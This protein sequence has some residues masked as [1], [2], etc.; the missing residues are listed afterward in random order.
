MSVFRIVG[1]RKCAFAGLFFFLVLT[2][3]DCAYFNTFYLAKRDFN[4]GE[5]FRKRDGEVRPDNRKYYTQAIE[6]ASL[7]LQDYRKSRYVDDSLSIIGMSYFQTGDYVR[8]KTKF[9]EI[10][11]AFP[12]GNYAEEAKFYK[13]RCLLETGMPDQ[14]RILFNE[15]MTAGSKSMRGRSGL[16]LAEI[17]SRE[18]GWEEMIRSADTVLQSSPDRE[19]LRG[20]LMYR[21]EGLFQLGKF[22]DAA[23]SF[24]KLQGVKLEPRER[25]RVNSL[26]A[27][28]LAHLKK[29]DD[30]LGL[31]ESLQ[32]KGNMAPFAPGIRLEIG[33]IYEL[34]GDQEKAVDAFR[35]M[36]A[37]FPDS[38]DG[39]EA[40]HR[41][42]IITLRDLSKAQEARDA[43]AKATLN[44]KIPETWFTD[45]ID[46]AAQIDS[47]KARTDRI[48]KL[49][50]KPEQA[51]HERF[52]L[53]ELLTY[54]LDHPEAALE[55]YKLILEEAPKTEYAV[56]SDYLIKIAALDTSGAK[57]DESEKEIMRAIVEK[58][59]DSHFSQELKVRL[60]VI[61]LPP[62]VK[63]LNEA[64]AARLEGKPSDAY[65]KLY[66]AVADSFPNSRSSYQARFLIAWCWEHELKDRAK[67]L[68]LYKA[69]ALERMNEYNRDIVNLASSKILLVND[70][71]KILE[72]SKKNIAFYDSEIE[73][74]S[75]PEGRTRAAEVQNTAP[76]EESE[77][78]EMKKVR[79][80]NARI[81]SRY[82]SF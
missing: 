72:E 34:K 49:K 66:Q 50:D 68:E 80:R 9:D 26:L 69:L 53:A 40:W 52:L 14:A 63:L 24:Q 77:F 37:D 62:D 29:Y 27:L 16:M 43:F 5:R 42:G 38:T 67:A 8:A 47:M 17:S 32:S 23:A 46:K 7:I 25:F 35:K 19:T 81:R 31:L 59:P 30:A 79:A 13:A 65:M 76:A 51:A 10:L 70:E 36:A 55:Q 73:Q 22:E 75:S 71:K 33:K 11:I 48:D 1:L 54:S 78:G 28:S 60:G 61:D 41:V 45:A 39:R 6:N 64:D 2:L 21:G 82:Y 4:T 18:E 57:R 3:A 44:K 58:Y 15:L 12:N 20:A 74:Y 56:R